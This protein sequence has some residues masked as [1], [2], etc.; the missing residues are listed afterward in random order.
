MDLGLHVGLDFRLSRLGPGSR[1]WNN[2]KSGSGSRS[3][4]HS[5]PER[6]IELD[7]FI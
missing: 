1:H 7:L 3:E 2:D 6:R 4:L 5:G